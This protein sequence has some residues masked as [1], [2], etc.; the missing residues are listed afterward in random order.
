MMAR[1]KIRQRANIGSLTREDMQLWDIMILY[2]CLKMGYLT[3]Q[4]WTFKLLNHGTMGKTGFWMF[5]P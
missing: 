3:T 2:T 5:I 4:L 1:S